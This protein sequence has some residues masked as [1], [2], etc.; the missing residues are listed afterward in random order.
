[1]AL[2]N[3]AGEARIVEG[4]VGHESVRIEL[5]SQL[6]EDLKF[7][8]EIWAVP[9]QQSV[10]VMTSLPNDVFIMNGKKYCEC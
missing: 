8:V 7:H 10:G 9:T 4:G 1:M 6:A 2:D 5:R 3:R